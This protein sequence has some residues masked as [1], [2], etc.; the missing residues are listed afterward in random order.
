[1]NGT[2]LAVTAIRKETAET[3]IMVHKYGP[4]IF[5]TDKKEIW[6]FVNSLGEFRPYV[7][8]VKA[9]SNG[10]VYSLPVNLHTIN[11]LFGKSFTPAEAKAF[12]ETLADKSITDPRNFEE[13]ALSFIGKELYYAFFYGYT[14]KQW[15]CEPSEL[16]A[17]ILKRIPVRFNYDDNYH[18]NHLH[19]HT[20]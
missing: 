9:M 1:M 20:G 4:H 19:G 14:K 10:K 11:Q 18:N 12:L 7:H 3:G 5:N 6:D 2:I 16:P 15:G 13:Q 8:R 17:S